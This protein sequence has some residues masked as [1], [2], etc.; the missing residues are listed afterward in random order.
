MLTLLHGAEG[1]AGRTLG[2][3]VERREEAWQS[4]SLLTR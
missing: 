1:G 4:K 2:D 3:G